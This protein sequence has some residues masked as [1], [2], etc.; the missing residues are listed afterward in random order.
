[1]HIISLQKSVNAEAWK[2]IIRTLQAIKV[3]K[4]QTI[5]TE[6]N[7]EAQETVVKYIARVGI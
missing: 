5:N 3:E 6:I 1:M 7:S 4:K 2:A